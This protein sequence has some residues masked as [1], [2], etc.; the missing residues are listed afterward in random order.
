LQA[1]QLA[2]PLAQTGKTVR[3]G[4]RDGDSLP[5]ADKEIIK[6]T[7]ELA[8]KKGWKMSQVALSWIEKRVSSP[9]IGFS[10]ISR[11]EEALE[12]RGKELTE[13]EEKYLEEPYAAI[14][15]KGFL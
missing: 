6:R 12:A 4:N 7:Q 5:D 10:S 2:R 8:E 14:T 13:D 15:V 11:L 9:I 3:S 1:G